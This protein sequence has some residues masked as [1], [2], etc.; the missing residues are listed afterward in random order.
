GSVYRHFPTR[1]SLLEALYDTASTVMADSIPPLPLTLE[2]VPDMASKARAFFEVNPKLTQ[3][4]SIAL[5]ANNIEPA[6]RQQRDQGLEQL[7]AGANPRFNSPVAKQSA[8]IIQHLT[9]SLTW[10]ILRQRFGLTSEETSQ[11][12]DWALKTL[13]QDIVKP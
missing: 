12:L 5:L 11:A 1:E 6:S 9:S 3:A 10:A 2:A 13:V 7:V 4:F 8:A